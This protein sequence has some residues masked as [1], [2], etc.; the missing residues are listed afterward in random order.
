MQ[1][2]I[3]RS[4]AS[5]CASACFSLLGAF[6]F[7]TTAHA[8]PS[9]G[10]P[11]DFPSQ[12]SYGKSIALRGMLWV[13]S[14]A[15]KGAVVLVHGSS[16]WNDFR[17]GHYGRALSAAGYAAL[18]IDVFGPRGIRNTV[19]DQSLIS[20]LQMTR[21]AFFARRFLVEKGFAADRLAIM[22]FSKGG[23]V[24]LSAA[25]RN[26]LPAELDRFAAAIPFYPG[27]TFRPRTPKPAGIIFMALGEKDD[28]TGIKPCQDI[29]DNFKNAGG[30]ISV[31]IYPDATH[32]FDGNPAKTGMMNLR[33]VENYMDCIVFVEEDG[34]TTFA[35][36][37]YALDDYSSIVAD[38]RKT[39]MKRGAT[40]W[41]NMREKEI[42]TRDVIDFLN[43]SFVK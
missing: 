23:G 22:G 11:V 16:G 20:T 29:A 43:N 24:A 15:A 14:G 38:M 42:A 13:P 3:H 2:A 30:K 1:L 25:D 19:D 28:Y 35:G 17:E 36:K 26:V 10:I 5:I 40:I 31:K 37:K 34:Q 39:C 8:Q 32:A 7:F 12:D 6:L 41:T 4:L 33:S 18:A 27:C 21:D 9:G